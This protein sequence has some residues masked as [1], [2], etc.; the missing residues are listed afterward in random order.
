MIINV[1]VVVDL[2]ASADPANVINVVTEKVNLELSKVPGV[3]SS[4]VNT[5]TLEDDG[6]TETPVIEESDV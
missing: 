4:A 5:V 1:R 2:E 6:P 3:S